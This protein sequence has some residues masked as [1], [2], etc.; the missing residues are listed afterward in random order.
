MRRRCYIRFLAACLAVSV[1]HSSVSAQGSYGGYSAPPGYT[2]VPP[3]PG[4]GLPYNPVNS[5]PSPLPGAVNHTLG[6]ITPGEMSNSIQHGTPIKKGFTAGRRLIT[7]SNLAIL[8][9]TLVLAGLDWYF[10]QAKD[11]STPTGPLDEYSAPTAWNTTNVNVNL[12]RNKYGIFNGTYQYYD[13]VSVQWTAWASPTATAQTGSKNY[14]LAAGTAGDINK[15]RI[16][17]ENEA[18]RLFAQ[19]SVQQ[20]VPAY[21]W[22]LIEHQTGTIETQSRYGK[23]R[24]QRTAHDL[25]PTTP[26]LASDFTNRVLP[27]YLN[28]NPAPSPTALPPGTTWDGPVPNTNQ[29]NDNPY[30]DPNLDTDRDGWTD[31]A[32]YELN[33]LPIDPGQPYDI[34]PP[35]Y[36]PN[37]DYDDDGWSDKNENDN[38]TPLDNPDQHPDQQ[39]DRPTTPIQPGMPGYDE[40]FDPNEDTDGDGTPNDKDLDDDADGIPSESD[41]EPLV[42]H[43]PNTDPGNDYDGDGTPNE[44]DSDDDNDGIPD[45]SDEQPLCPTFLLPQLRVKAQPKTPTATASLTK[46]TKTTITTAYR[47]RPTRSPTSLMTRPSIRAKTQTATA[48]PTP[49]TQIRWFRMN[50]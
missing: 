16:E 34:P 41:P 5:T 17:G 25:M 15:Y 43:D 23:T 42:P 8:G 32:E 46:A 2:Y 47:T 19:I 11:A 24:S 21:D 28:A 48:Y 9:G 6:S 49:K 33:H 13:E 14:K 39:P 37:Y 18:S 7:R 3:N 1:F 38:K 27:S 31:P 29:W 22:Q 45:E 26:D 4:N 12:Q 44:S 20:P 10:K 50:R 35:N 36:D 30:S 40:Q